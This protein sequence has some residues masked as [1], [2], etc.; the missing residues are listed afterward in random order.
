MP[1][2]RNWEDS[3]GTLMPRQ[4]VSWQRMPDVFCAL[5]SETVP[6]ASETVP[7]E[8]NQ[9]AHYERTSSP[10]PVTGI[11]TPKLDLCIKLSDVRHFERCKLLLV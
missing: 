5:A 3:Q 11:C 2:A 8:Y 10:Y 9:E 6:L 4:N 7:E 1:Y